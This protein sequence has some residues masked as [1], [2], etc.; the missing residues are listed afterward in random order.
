[1]PL[2]LRR[3]PLTHVALGSHLK[4]LPPGSHVPVSRCPSRGGTSLRQSADPALPPASRAARAYLDV[5]FFHPFPDGNARSA[6]L[7]LAYVLD[8]NGVRLDQVSPLPI[9]RYA[10][11]PVGAADLA[12]LVAILICGV[13]RRAA[14]SPMCRERPHEGTDTTAALE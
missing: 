14:A 7:T 5:A 11:D 9:A 6:L 10:D 3:I 8:L 13:H 12:A 2:E 1:M 4:L